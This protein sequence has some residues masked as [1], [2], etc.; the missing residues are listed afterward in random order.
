MSDLKKGDLVTIK[1]EYCRPEELGQVYECYDAPEKGRVGVRLQGWETM[2]LP[3]TEVVQISMLQK[4]EA[5]MTVS[6]FQALTIE[7]ASQLNRDQ[8]IAFL[9]WNDRNGVYTDEDCEAEGYDLLTL[10]TARLLVIK[11]IEESD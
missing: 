9:A 5:V 7:G 3:S 2:N 6:E 10:E 1:P 4:V 8:L 11:A